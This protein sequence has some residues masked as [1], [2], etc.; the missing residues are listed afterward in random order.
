MGDTIRVSLTEDPEFEIPVAKALVNRYF[1]RE[2][3]QSSIP[4]PD[5]SLSG[6]NTELL[7]YNPFD[8]SRRKTNV[9]LNIGDHKVPVVIADLSSEKKI[10]PPSLRPLGY[11]YSEVKRIIHS[12]LLHFN[13]E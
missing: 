4:S 12:F 7:P 2:K 9:V 5:V 3:K 11:N 13:N 10:T 8:Y 1:N 6:K